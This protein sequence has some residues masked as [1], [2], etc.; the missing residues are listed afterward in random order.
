MKIKEGYLLREIAGTHVVVPIGERVIEFK[1]MMTLNETG[2]FIWEQLQ[3][4][5]TFEDVLDS[6]LSS[7]EID[8]GTAKTD[9]EEFISVAGKN[10]VLVQ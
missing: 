4:E 6:I 3:S 2:M 10:G 9:L 8:E 1:G 5:S 7:Y